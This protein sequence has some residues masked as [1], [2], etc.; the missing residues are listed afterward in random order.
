MKTETPWRSTSGEPLLVEWWVEL[1]RRLARGALPDHRDGHHRA[2]GAGAGAAPLARTHRRGRA[3]PSG[4][5]SSATSTTARSSGSSRSRSRSGSRR[6]RSPPDPEAAAQIL[7]EASD[8]LAL[9]LEE[10]RELA[11]GIHPAVLTDRGPDRRAGDARGAG[12][13]PRRAADARGAPRA[14]RRGGRLLRRRGGTDERR[15]VRRRP[16]AVNVTVEQRDGHVVVEVADDGV[17][18][19]EPAAGSGLS[20]LADRV[21]ALDGTLASR[22]RPAA[23]PRERRDPARA[24]T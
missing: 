21:A 20:G 5:A 17:G 1:A 11:R 18:G 4:G 22:A 7:G 6:R 16:S 13:A 8:E 23:G 19:A 3:R 15:Q 12:A 14:A 9:A 24:S 2:Q 10:L